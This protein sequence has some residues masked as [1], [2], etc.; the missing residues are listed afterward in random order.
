M[1]NGLPTHQQLLHLF[2]DGSLL[3]LAGK[4]GVGATASRASRLAASLAR[5]VCRPGETR[6]A[7]EAAKLNGPSPPATAIASGQTTPTL[8]GLFRRQGPTRGWG[9]TATR[10]ASSMRTVRFLAV[11]G[12]LGV[13]ATWAHVVTTA[14]AGGVSIPTAG[15]TT[16]AP[17]VPSTD[18]RRGSVREGPT[19]LGRRDA[20]GRGVGDL[21]GDVAFTDTDG[22]PGRL[23]DYR[24][25]RA[26]VVCF[27]E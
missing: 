20:A 15:P 2:P 16:T 13:A 7:S 17:A 6:L 4:A 8:G 24:G 22:K 12:C 11:L 1:A 9:R 14:R 18:P 19:V 27:T 23:S 21:V 5:R 3:V 26:T 25:R 10:R